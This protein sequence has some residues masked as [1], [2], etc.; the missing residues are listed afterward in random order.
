MKIKFCWQ[1]FEKFSNTKFHENPSSESTDVP[2]GLTDRYTDMRDETNSR[3]SL[4]Y[5]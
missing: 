3:L 2:C 4:I 5:E 1:F